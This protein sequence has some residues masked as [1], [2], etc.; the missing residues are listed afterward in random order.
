M[1]T[2]DDQ[3]EGMLDESGRVRLHTT[4]PSGHPTIQ[5]FTWTEWRDGL[6]ADTLSFEC[7]FCHARWKPSTMQRAAIL[8]GFEPEW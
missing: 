7:L 5:A 1:M 4:C 3:F 6:A 2:D 8:A